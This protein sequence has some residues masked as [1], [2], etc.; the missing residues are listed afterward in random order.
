M[1]TYA[2][3]SRSERELLHLL[4]N[5]G[6]AVVRAPSSGGALSPLDV[7][8]IKRGLVLGFEIKAWAHKPKIDKQQLAGLREWCDKAGAVGLIAWRTTGKWLFLRLEDAEQ[9]KYEDEN[10]MEKDMLF[11][12]LDYR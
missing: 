8:A 7:I 1:K 11:K 5:R 12:A 3:G 4:N 2:K 10:W 9:D 6:F